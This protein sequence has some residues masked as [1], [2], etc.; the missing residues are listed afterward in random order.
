LNGRRR[1]FYL[2]LV[3]LVLAT[4]TWAA[5]TP[6]FHTAA[7]VS[8]EPSPAATLN[9]PLPPPADVFIQKTGAYPQGN[10]LVMVQLTSQEL[11]A[12]QADGT[13]SFITL[14]DLGHQVILR[15][16]GQQ[17]DATAND[18]TFTAIASV[19]E[20]DLA[21]RAQADQNAL[22]AGAG[23]L[24]QFNG[25]TLAGQQPQT[26]F[27]Y[28]GFEAG[29]VV[30]LTRAVVR[31]QPATP[32]PALATSKGMVK[33]ASGVNPPDQFAE[34]VLM[35]RDPGVVTDP[36]RTVDP[37]TGA[38]NPFGVWTFNHLM[39]EMANQPASGIDPSFFAENWLQNWTANPTINSFPVPS[40]PQMQA[41]IDQWRAAS[42]GGKLDLTK[43]PLR[44]LAI[45][46][47]V[48]L[49]RTTG[50]GGGYSGN[51]TGNFL[52]AGEARFI[53][54]FVLPP[55]WRLQGGYGPGGAPVINPNGCQA[56]PFSVI[57][58]YRVPKC[59]C[60]AVR[61]WAQNWV[62]LNNYVPGTPDYNG[63]LEQL[64]E[65]FVRANANLARPNGSAIGQI[66]SNEIA[67]QA[68]WELREFQLTQFPWSLV[69][70]T[71]T[72]DTA[73]DSFNGT[74]IFTNWI[75][76]NIVPNISGPNWDQPVPAVPLF[77]G[78]NFQGAHPQAPGPG[79]F[80]NGPGLTTL[81]DNWGRHRA[82]LNSCNGCHAG[83]TG[84]IFVHVDPATPGL[85]AG[86]SGFLTGI[87]VND[88]AFGSPARTFNDLL[89]R[90]ADIQ[91]VANMSCLQFPTVNVTAVMA[92]LQSTGHL[93]PDL[94]AGAPPTPAEERLSVSVDD[95]KRNVILEVH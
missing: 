25:R 69:N 33:T 54:G 59:H 35:I 2:T 83:E 10:V 17:G 94:F 84:T 64:T 16:D 71:T 72:N 81:A 7:T 9:A 40:R 53:F 42:G 93:P 23:P 78:G 92:S 46:S 88:P 95:M 18:G 19:D 43:A 89:R 61:A 3:I 49:R 30:R 14:G 26:A 6:T 52:D 73:D 76:G 27:D 68:P 38:G 55:G 47:R 45:V 1:A 37:C 39:T 24:P 13:Q 82:S 12:K 62:D 74:P 80:W 31:L 66:R 5:R 4:S 29:R 34:R 86:L 41:I 56:L 60:E 75:Q 65:Q 21:A 36:G 50:G 11:A 51:A 8:G 70:E 58:E 87:T 48:D 44:L 85:P 15:N 32:A 22:S 77:F 20:A 79:F 91:Q 67:L 57:F 90:E 63:R 28:A